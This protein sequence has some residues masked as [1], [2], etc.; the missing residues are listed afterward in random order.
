MWPPRGLWPGKTLYKPD[1]HLAYAKPPPL[2]KH[3]CHAKPPPRLLPQPVQGLETESSVM[4]STNLLHMFELIH[5]ILDEFKQLQ[6]SRWKTIN[7]Q[8]NVFREFDIEPPPEDFVIQHYAPSSVGTNRQL[9]EAISR[10]QALIAQI[11]SY[12]G[13]VE[14][15]QDLKVYFRRVKN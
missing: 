5:E 3:H 12:G 6:A 8:L 4:L 2:V 14:V 15:P 11:K 13:T 1:K 9:V 7:A 10:T